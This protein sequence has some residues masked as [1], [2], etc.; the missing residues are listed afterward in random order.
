MTALDHTFSDIVQ[1]TKATDVIR[2]RNVPCSRIPDADHKL[3]AAYQYWQGKRKDGLLPARRDMDILDL[4]ALMGHMHVVDVADREPADYR[5]RLFASNVPLD[6]FKNYT[7]MRLGDYPSEAYRRTVMEDYL[8]CVTTGVPLYQQIVASID[9]VSYS[10]SRLLL[11]VADD[12][13]KVNMLFACSN[14]RK[15]DDLTV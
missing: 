11:P 3:R 4:K 6:R 8:A 9:Y 2:R 13:R 7:N 10:Y 14:D 1:I 15:F 5:Y 12:G